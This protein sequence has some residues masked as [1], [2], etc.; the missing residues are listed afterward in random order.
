MSDSA[1]WALRFR[2]ALVYSAGNHRRHSSITVLT[3]CVWRVIATV[4]LVRL[5]HAVRCSGDMRKSSC[6]ACDWQ[7][8]LSTQS[9]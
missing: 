1:V 4:S 5:D 9:E 3:S 6:T 2:G 8:V 7:T